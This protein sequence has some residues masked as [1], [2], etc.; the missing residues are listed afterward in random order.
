[1]S[2]N[3]SLASKCVSLNNE[4]CM[5]W[6][7]VIDLNLVQL[8]YYPFIISLD[9]FSRSC[10]VVDDLSAKICVP[11]EKKYVHVKAVNMITRINEAKT[12]MKHISCDCKCKFNSTTCNSNKKWNK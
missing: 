5:F 7:T 9:K 8:N 4:P 2:S 10:N 12:L 6:S 1:M 3:G 11:S